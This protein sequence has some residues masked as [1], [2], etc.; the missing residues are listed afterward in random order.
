MLSTMK[1]SWIEPPLGGIGCY[2]LFRWG[3]FNW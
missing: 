1:W 2:V 3:E